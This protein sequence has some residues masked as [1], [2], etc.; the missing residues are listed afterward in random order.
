MMDRRL[1]TAFAG[2]LA[3]SAFSGRAFAGSYLVRA[4]LL[5]SG[6][7]RDASQIGARPSDREL[8]RLVHKVA[9]GR[10]SAA[11][12]MEVPKEVTSA[13]PHLLLLLE[14]HERA[15]EA[16][17]RGD[18]TQFLVLRNKAREETSTFVAVL[19]DHGY[20]LPNF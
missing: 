6:A 12:E 8:A 1:F 9:L 20:E 2:A 11:R 4:A 17:T 14:G 7:E 5:I 3:L 16:L 13:H 15:S 19:K 18:T 10:V